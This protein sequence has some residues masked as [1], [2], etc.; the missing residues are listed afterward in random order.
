M[1]HGYRSDH[2]HNVHR[3]RQLVKEQ[4]AKKMEEKNK[5]KKDILQERLA[6]INGRIYNVEQDLKSSFQGSKIVKEKLDNLK[7]Q[8]EELELKLKENDIN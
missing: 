6:E 7:K 2:I 4:E 8:R 1:S 3:K 5:T